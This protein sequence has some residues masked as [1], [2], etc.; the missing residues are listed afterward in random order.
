MSLA[1][2]KGGSS[3]LT[4][5]PVSEHGF[6]DVKSDFHDHVRLRSSWRLHNV[7]S[8]CPC[9]ALFTADHAQIKLSGFIHM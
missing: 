3:A 8:V 4:T 6:F 2:E 9:S 7:P 1:R 5:V